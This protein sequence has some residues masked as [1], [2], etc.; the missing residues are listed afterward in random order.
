MSDWRYWLAEQPRDAARLRRL[1]RDVR[2]L[3]RRTIR[4]VFRANVVADRGQQGRAAG[5]GRD[6]A[7][8]GRHHRRHRPF[9][10]HGVRPEQLP[11][12]V[13]R[14]RNGL[15]GG[16]RGRRRSRRG[17]CLRRAERPDRHLWP[18]CSRSSTT[19]ATGAVFFGLALLLRPT[20]GG[21][22]YGPLA[23][24]LTGRVFGVLPASLVALAAVVLVVWVPLRRS[25][26]GRAAYAVG[27]S[28]QRGLHV[29]RSGRAGEIRRLCPVRPRSRRSAACS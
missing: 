13:D 2:D 18:A 27:S 3:C 15:V 1:R 29:G 25:P 10:R 26:I 17:S 6:G 14:R 9:G 4:R 24:A 16:A 20:P 5:A 21:D 23:D 7:D 8:L 22:V 19:I 11:R 28:E 12:L